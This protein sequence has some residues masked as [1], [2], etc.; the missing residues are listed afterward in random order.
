MTIEFRAVLRPLPGD[1]LYL[2]RWSKTNVLS[3]AD[4]L[5]Q[6]VQ[7]PWYDDAIA[8]SDCWYWTGARA[9]RKQ[10]GYGRLRNSPAAIRA[11]GPIMIGAHRAAYESVR[12]PIPA[13]LYACHHCDRI[14]CC[15][16][17]H[18]FPGTPA[19]NTADMLA[20]QRHWSQLQSRNAVAV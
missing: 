5:W 14:L 3:L 9:A 10:G 6:K 2:T 8:W 19:E 7:G 20:K 4:R 15:N 16:P 18:I 1:V 11:G 13:G 12:A 17:T